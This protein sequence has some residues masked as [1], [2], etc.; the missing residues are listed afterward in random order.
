M[1]LVTFQLLGLNTPKNQLRRRKSMLISSVH[2]CLYLL[3][4]NVLEEHLS[5]KA[6]ERLLHQPIKL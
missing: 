4:L 6:E 1:V 5:E 3:R 2:G